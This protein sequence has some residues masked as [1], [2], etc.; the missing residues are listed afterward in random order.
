MCTLTPIELYLYNMFQTDN[1]SLVARQNNCPKKT[2]LSSLVML[3][4]GLFMMS[5]TVNVSVTTQQRL[6]HAVPLPVIHTTQAHKWHSTCLCCVSLKSFFRTC[7]GSPPNSGTLSL[8]PPPP[9]H[10]APACTPS[11]RLL[12]LSLT[13]HYVLY[14]HAFCLQGLLT[15]HQDHLE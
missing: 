12:W 13:V 11:F 6:L 10:T 9:T 5:F 4:R 1:F 8:S 3:W 15:Q 2:C 14:W 7:D